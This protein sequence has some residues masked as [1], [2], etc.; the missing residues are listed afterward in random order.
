M[1][2]FISAF[3]THPMLIFDLDSSG[4]SSLFCSEMPFE[5]VWQ[6]K[7]KGNWFVDPD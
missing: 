1:R 7:G 3:G 6:G 5:E 4:N 2:S